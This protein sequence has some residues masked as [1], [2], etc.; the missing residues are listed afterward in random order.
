VAELK[1]IS[2]RLKERLLTESIAVTDE[3]IRTHVKNILRKR[4]KKNAK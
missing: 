1:Y 4:E 2:D 3:K